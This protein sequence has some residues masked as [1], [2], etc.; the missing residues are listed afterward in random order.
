[1]ARRAYVISGKNKYVGAGLAFL[2]AVCAI[3]PQVMM[4]LT[5][6]QTIPPMYGDPATV[7]QQQTMNQYLELCARSLDVNRT[8]SYPF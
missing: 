6:S 1:M 5:A 7:T 8:R 4:G 2:V 3:Y